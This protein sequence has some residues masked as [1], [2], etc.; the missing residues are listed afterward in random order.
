MVVAAADIVHT[1]LSRPSLYGLTNV[2]WVIYCR[3]VVTSLS[4]EM[5]C[6]AMQCSVHPLIQYSLTPS[7][8]SCI[9]SFLFRYHLMQSS[10]TTYYP[11]IL[12]N[13]TWY[14]LSLLLLSFLSFSFPFLSL[15]L[16]SFPDLPFPFPSSPF[17]SWSPL[18]CPVVSFPFLVSGYSSNDFD[19]VLMDLQMPIMDGIEATRRF[20]EFESQDSR[21]HLHSLPPLHLLTPPYFLSSF[22]SPF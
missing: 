3:H 5:R 8:S 18:S 21:H 16:L 17:L 22:F 2:I 11:F 12:P 6:D 13:I 9:A 1:M 14:P 19:V 20:R 4:H 7:S 15:L 10:D